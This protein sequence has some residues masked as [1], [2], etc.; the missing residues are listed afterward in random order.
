MLRITSYADRLIAD[1][2][3]LEWPESLKEMQRNWIGRSVGAQIDFAVAEPE[4]T[5]TSINRLREVHEDAEDDLTI[6]VFTTRPDTLYGAT[7]MVLAPEHPMVDRITPPPHRET[8]EAYR[9]VI[10]GKS[11]R[12]RQADT[13]DKTGCFIGAYAINPANGREAADLHRR[14]RPDGIRH[15]RDHGRAGPRRARLRLRQEVRPADPPRRPGQG[16]ARPDERR[17]HRRRHRHQ[18][19]PGRRA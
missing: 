14:L 5:P 6:T 2:D 18:L 8:I 9:T 15:R 13:K 19:R 7:Y 12:D 11:D 10:A 1:L 16:V 17:L 3:Q 4:D